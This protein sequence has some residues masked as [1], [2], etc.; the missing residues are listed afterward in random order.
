[1]KSI[2]SLM[3]AASLLSSFSVQAGWVTIPGSG[4]VTVK[5]S[6]LKERQFRTTVRQQYD[7]SC[8]A[9]ALATLLTY[10]YHDPISED[11]VF[12]EMWEN[13]DQDKIHR[14][15]FSLL[16]I[17]QYLEAH[18]YS[19]DGYEAPLDKLAEV[20]I[21]AIV[22]IRE[23]GYNHFVVVKGLRNGQVAVGD[24]SAGAKIFPREEFE[25]MLINRILFVI[26]GAR[27]KVVF[28]SR[29]DWHIREKAPLGIA[30]GPTDL[31]NMI[32]LRRSPSDL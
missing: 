22:L 27:D 7:Y 9:A 14:E 24:P 31:A 25:K 21:P 3:L 19:A 13:G 12:Q 11:K 29:Q 10:H 6:S 2:S 8:G 15:G 30:A 32:L 26:N 20:G 1:M 5:V 18:D 17:K 16:D 4:S 23:N 28:D